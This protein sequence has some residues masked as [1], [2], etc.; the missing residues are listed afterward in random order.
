MSIQS[1]VEMLSVQAMEAYAKRK[2]MAGNEAMDLFHQYQVFERIIVQHEYLHQVDFEEVMEFVESIIEE[3]SNS[4][5]LFHGATAIF[6]KID[7]NK[8]KNRRDIG[9]RVLYNDFRT[10]GKGMGVSS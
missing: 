3:A 2:H 6:D 5:T 10:T 9:K 7:L 4:L 1:D 8:S